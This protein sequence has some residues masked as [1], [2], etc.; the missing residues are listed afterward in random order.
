MGSGLS[1]ISRKCSNTSGK[2]FKSYGTKQESKYTG[3]LDGNNL[4]SHAMSK[5]LRKLRFKW[6]D[7]TDFDLKIITITVQKVM[8]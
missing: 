4:Y 1:C 8:F 5:F 7:K 2:Y 3:Y 6:I